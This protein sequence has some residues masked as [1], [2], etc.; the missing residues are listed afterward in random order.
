MELLP[1][2]ANITQICSV[3][4]L[5]DITSKSSFPFLDLT[6]E[7]SSYGLSYDYIIILKVASAFSICSLILHI[8][9]G[10]TEFKEVKEN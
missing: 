2:A 6:S 10:S 1:H 4:I 9:D 3:Q 7:R 8:F 5:S